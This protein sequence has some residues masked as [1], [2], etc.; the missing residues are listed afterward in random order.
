MSALPLKK[1]LSRFLNRTQKRKTSGFTLIELLVVIFI[2]GGIITGLMYLVVELLGVDQ[3]ESSRTETQREM[4]LAMDYIAEDLREAVYIY[5]GA[6]LVGRN[7]VAATAPG[8]C[9][10]TSPL[11]N[12][13]PTQLQPSPNII[14]VIA[15]WKQQPLPPDVKNLCST[16]LAAANAQNI[17]CIAASSYALVVYYISR[18]KERVNNVDTWDGNA[19]I[20]RYALAEFQSSGVVRS[21]GYI[22]PDQEDVSFATWPIARDGTNRQGNTRPLDNSAV[23]VDFLD[24]QEII[25]GAPASATATCPSNYKITPDRNVFTAGIPQIRSFYACL[26][27]G[28]PGASSG[29]TTGSQSTPPPTGV[30]RDAILYIRGNAQGRPGIRRADTFLPFLE[31]RVLVRGVLS[32]TPQGGSGTTP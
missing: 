2:A 20:K 8:Y 18:D 31:T 6:C 22:L 7:V 24:G 13:L 28:S 21:Q 11:V 23:L 14:P 15:F 10:R 30:N 9:P 17:P 27:P 3:R 29:T 25:T 26:D 16:N 32:K 19:R 1:Q 4:Q 12:H 5:D